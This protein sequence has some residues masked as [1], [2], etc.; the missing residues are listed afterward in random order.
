MLSK[1]NAKL[2]SDN[3]FKQ[4]YSKKR[5]ALY[6]ETPQLHV[7][8]RKS[9]VFMGFFDEKNCVFWNATIETHKKS[10]K[11]GEYTCSEMEYT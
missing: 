2:E 1:N 4:L 3:S 6:T 10:Y 5:S 11:T 8:P 7:S 9:G